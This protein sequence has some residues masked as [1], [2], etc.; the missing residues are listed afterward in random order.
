LLDSFEILN[1]DDTELHVYSSTIIYGSGYDERYAEQYKALFER[2]SNM[3]NVVCHGYAPND[4]VIKALQQAHVFAYPSVF[5]E[6]CCL[7]MIEAGAAGCTLV[8]QNLGALAETGAEFA[9]LVPIRIDNDKIAEKYA[10]ALNFT[11][12][13]YWENEEWRKIQSRFFNHYYS[14]DEKIKQWRSLFEGLNSSPLN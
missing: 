3:K 2:A 4:E 9:T 1:R 13:S 12:D 7:A 10:E 8:G 11:L 5:E 14:W 6:T